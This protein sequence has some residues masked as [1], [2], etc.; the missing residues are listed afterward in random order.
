[1][2]FRADTPSVCICGKMKKREIGQCEQSAQDGRGRSPAPG[3]KEQK[4]RVGA[5]PGKNRIGGIRKDRGPALGRRRSVG[6]QDAFANGTESGVTGRRGIRG[7]LIRAVRPARNRE[8]AERTVR[9]CLVEGKVEEIGKDEQEGGGE[10][11]SAGPDSPES[12]QKNGRNR[13]HHA[14]RSP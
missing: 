7:R 1:M 3:G 4:R 12:L 14:K 11:K 5:D 10:K 8:R 6:N 13:I 9:R 2:V